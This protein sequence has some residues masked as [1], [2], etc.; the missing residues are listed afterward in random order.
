VT[1]PVVEI[2]FVIEDDGDTVAVD[3]AFDVIVDE[4]LAVIDV[5]LKAETVADT[6]T[7]SVLLD[8]R[9][10]LVSSDIVGSAVTVD[11]CVKVLVEIPLDDTLMIELEVIVDVIEVEDEYVTNGERVE[12]RELCKVFEEI[13]VN[14][15]TDDCVLLLILDIVATLETELIVEAVTE[16][17][18]VTVEENVGLLVVVPI[19]DQVDETVIV[20]ALSLDIKDND[21]KGE[22][23]AIEGVAVRLSVGTTVVVKVPRLEEAV[24]ERVAPIESDAND[25]SESKKEVAGVAEELIEP[26]DVRD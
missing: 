23:E 10:T 11:I 18:E 2:E 12:V 15:S 17:G 7:V 9:E 6:Q 8:E 13:A 3:V 21:A 16:T 14:E 5:V 24:G 26:C 22:P 19:F 4:T 1:E 20:P 25:V